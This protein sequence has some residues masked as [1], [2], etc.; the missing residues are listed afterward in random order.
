MTSQVLFWDRIKAFGFI[1]SGDPNVRDF[2][3]HK[4]NL[5]NRQYLEVGDIVEFEFGKDKKGRTIAINVKV[6]E[7]IASPIT[8]TQ[9]AAESK[10]DVNEQLQ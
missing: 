8:V 2:F 6:V 9:T 4:A 5:V 3:V 7:A 10:G 1:S